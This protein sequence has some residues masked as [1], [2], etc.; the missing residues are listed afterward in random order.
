M[1]TT[2]SHFLRQAACVLTLPKFLIKDPLQPRSPSP[3]GL[4]LVQ[5]RL[6]PASVVSCPVDLSH[7]HPS[8]AS[9]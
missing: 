5:V 8:V 2:P 7:R 4:G 9:R 6:E 1:A 3:P